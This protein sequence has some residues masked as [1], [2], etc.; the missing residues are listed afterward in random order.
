MVDNPLI[1]SGAQIDAIERAVSSERF[2]RYLVPASDRS[3]ALEWYRWNL[4]L[5]AAFYGP[6]QCLEVSLRNAVHD[7]LAPN[8]GDSWYAHASLLTS[9]DRETGRQAVDRV[10]ATGKPVT[11]GRVIAELSFGFWVG[12]FA[13]VYD[14]TLWRTD[15]Y[16]VFSPRPRRRELHDKLDRLRTL[17]NRIAHH[18][19]IYQRNLVDDY[20]RVCEV[21][22]AVSPE[23]CAWMEFNS[24][25]LDVLAA[26]PGGGTRF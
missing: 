25:A 20:R 26:G 19:P 12:L 1:W 9:R 18:E 13:N 6:L 16:R 10:A 5:S 24:Q 14:T 15:L 17:R 21:V 7:R 23:L 8:Y 3:G 2:A 11:P 4:A 22:R